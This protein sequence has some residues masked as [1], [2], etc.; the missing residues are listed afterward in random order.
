MMRSRTAL[1]LTVLALT[2][3]LAGCGKTVPGTALPA[4]GTAGTGGTT[5][6]NTN[7]DKL[8]RECTVVAIDDIGKSVGDQHVRGAV[9]QRRGLH[10]ESHRRRRGQRHGDP[11]LV[12]GGFARQ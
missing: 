8:L 11:Q 10:V 2:V 4:G 5:R 9:F 7:F 3:T 1:A 12:R 6:I